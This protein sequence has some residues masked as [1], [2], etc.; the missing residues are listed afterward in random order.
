MNKFLKKIRSNTYLLQIMT[1][2]SGTLMAQIVSFAFIPIMSRLY[3]P[4]EFG[5][6]SIFFALS[7]MIGMVS[8]LNYEQAIMLPKSNRD[9]QALVFLSI[10]VTISIVSILVIVLSIFYDFFLDYFK[11]YSYLIWILPISTLVIGLMQIFDAY[12]TRKEF[13]K[14]IATTKVIASFTTVAIQAISRYR[15]N[16]NGLV[17]GKVISDMLAVF[18]LISFN[19]KKQTLQLKYLSKRRVKANIKR[20]ENFPKYQSPSTLI[21][22]FSQNIP[23]LMF[24]SLFSPAISGFYSLTY[25]AMQTP[26]SLVSNSTRSVFYQK[27]SKMYANREDLYPLYMKTTLALLKLFIIPLVVILFFGEDLFV[28]VFGQE[29]SQSGVIAQIVIFWFLF[30]F[31]SPPTTVMFNIYGLQRVRLIIQ[32]VTLVFRVL[33]IYAGYY[34][35]GSY[36][37]SLILFV[38]V[39]VLHNGGVMIYIYKKIEEKRREIV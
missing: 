24:A 3:T 25:R 37:V 33:A 16:L 2:M 34:F 5:L 14:K 29:W 17:V 1:L 22:S 15:F 28:F 30:G 23:L 32:I 9:A 39:G 12:S 4:S 20:Y 36:I 7:S 18:L 13:Y 38:I 6:Y 10:L 31:I 11:G 19:I 21:N 8:S 26:L 35:Y 27:A